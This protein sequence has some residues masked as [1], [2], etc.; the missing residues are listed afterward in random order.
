M[1]ALGGV[2]RLVDDQSATANSNKLIDGVYAQPFSET[3]SY[4]LIRKPTSPIEPCFK[5]GEK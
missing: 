3:S 1:G 2:S 5:L 4:F